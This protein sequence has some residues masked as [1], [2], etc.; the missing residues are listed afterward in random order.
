MCKYFPLFPQKNLSPEILT[1]KKVEQLTKSPILPDCQVPN[2]FVFQFSHS[3]I[4][5]FEKLLSFLLCQFLWWEV[6]LGNQR[7]Y[8]T[9]IPGLTHLTQNVRSESGWEKKSLLRWFL[10][11]FVTF[12][13]WWMFN[14]KI[15]FL[16][17]RLI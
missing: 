4:E 10:A 15:R 11:K 17:F 1:Q 14:P 5:A 6:F 8:F 9:N 2:G 7:K 12:R 16:S 13:K 3:R